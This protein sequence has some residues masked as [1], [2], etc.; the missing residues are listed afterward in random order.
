MCI[1]HIM[2]EALTTV[3]NYTDNYYS[4]KLILVVD[5]V[6]YVESGFSSVI[7]KACPWG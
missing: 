2:C 4:T 7:I 3:Y 1:Q 5:Q 6:R